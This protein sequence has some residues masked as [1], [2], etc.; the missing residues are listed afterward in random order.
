VRVARLL[1][2]AKELSLKL[3]FISAGK[4]QRNN[5]NADHDSSGSA[6]FA[7]TLQANGGVPTFRE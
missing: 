5:S 3:S 6:L 7:V 1:R 2:G 4:A